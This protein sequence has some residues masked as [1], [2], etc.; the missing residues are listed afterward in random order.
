MK[1]SFHTSSSRPR[2]IFDYTGPYVDFLRENNET[3]NSYVL[4]VISIN[5]YKACCIKWKDQH[6][7]KLSGQLGQNLHELNALSGRTGPLRRSF[8]C[9]LRIAR[10]TRARPCAH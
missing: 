2:V 9:L 7:G 8:M 3:I 10:A 5:R 1:K 4:V 6:L